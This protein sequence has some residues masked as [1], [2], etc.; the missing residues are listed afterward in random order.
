MSISFPGRRRKTYETR[1][2]NE[3]INVNTFESK[4]LLCD[5]FFFSFLD[6]LKII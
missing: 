4:A 5:V 6:Q 3:R 2:Y 1:Q